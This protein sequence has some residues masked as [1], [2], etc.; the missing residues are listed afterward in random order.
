MEINAK[1][2]TMAI[3][4]DVSISYSVE[5][6]KVMLSDPVYQEFGH[7]LIGMYAKMID[8]QQTA[9]TDTNNHNS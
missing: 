6:L 2:D 9:T 7:M 1:I 5:E 8:N 3:K 4:A